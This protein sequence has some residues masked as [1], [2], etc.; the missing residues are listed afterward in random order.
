MIYNIEL[1][2]QQPSDVELSERR[3][4]LGIVVD[5]LKATLKPLNTSV[6]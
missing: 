1:E 5:Q 4:S 2:K 3:A 6:L